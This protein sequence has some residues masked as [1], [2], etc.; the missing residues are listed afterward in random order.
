MKKLKWQIT[1]LAFIIFV[2]FFGLILHSY[3]QQKY[4]QKL[5]WR[6][7]S[8][9]SYNQMQA[10]IS[11]FL[12]RE[13]ERNFSS[14]QYSIK[15]TQNAI[16]TPPHN[17]PKGLIGYFQYD[18]DKN[19]STPYLPKDINSHIPLKAKREYLHKKLKN[20]TSSLKH[21]L[22]LQTRENKTLYDV[23]QNS[24][25][26]LNNSNLVNPITQQ[27]QKSY[28][29]NKIGQ[30]NF[31]PNP[32]LK[33]RKTKKSYKKKSSI[34]KFFKNIFGG[35]SSKSSNKKEDRASSSSIAPEQEPSDD[36]D[37]EKGNTDLK[38]QFS[39]NITEFSDPFHAILLN[40]DY[41]AFHRKI[42]K[43]E[44]VYLQGFVV[45]IK[46]FY[47]WLI[48]QSYEN[49]DLPSFTNAQW[50][51]KNSFLTPEYKSYKKTLYLRHLGFPLGQIKYKISYQNLPELPLKNMIV[52]IS[53]LFSLTIL[54]ALYSIY[55]NA[56]SIIYLSQ[57]RQDFVSSITHE[58]KTPLTSIRMSA[59]LLNDEWIT[60]ED[61]KRRH[62]KIISKES[63]R[64]S[65]LIENVLQLS[66]LEKNIFNINP[67]EIDGN[68]FFEDTIKELHDF[69]YS[70]GFS[71]KKNIINNLGKIT[72][73]KDAFNQIVF[74]IVENS[75]KFSQNSTNKTI[76]INAYRENHDVIFEIQDYGP[77]IPE[78]E[79]KKVFDKFYR[80]ENELTRTTKGTGIGLAMVKMLC[81]AS[82]IQIHIENTQNKGLL[83]KLSIP[84]NN[85][86]NNQ[87]KTN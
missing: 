69:T 65:R 28:D 4:Q 21:F 6:D 46:T 75:L 87:I 48:S 67:Q 63:S 43:K 37:E 82:G 80:V 30:Q 79:M 13:E 40:K 34:T 14:Y 50:I 29:R 31:Y 62:Y 71:L 60:D 44:K 84:I 51:F 54:I 26:N 8:E 32:L 66:R 57:K 64:L 61:K 53:S 33:R 83:T 27:V 12:M 58:L 86:K 1:I 70:Q 20:L 25:L 49:T 42:W 23:S 2:S 59:E 39:E 55:K 38:D 41:I 76:E 9:R 10:R 7:I 47:K 68:K 74:N 15:N 85:A 24:N 45:E 36:Q 17:D 77:G 19:F 78:T 11:D 56:S 72:L 35:S 16:S 5:F 18:I 81:H 22:E 73:D 3:S 52:L